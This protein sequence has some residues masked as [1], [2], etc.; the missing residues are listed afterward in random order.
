MNAYFNT[1]NIEP[2]RLE[3]YATDAVA[4][5]ENLRPKTLLVK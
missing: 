2:V 5:A 3:S 4:A 1:A